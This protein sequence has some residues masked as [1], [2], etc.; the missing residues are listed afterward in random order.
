MQN[1]YL[2]VGEDKYL[3]T[4]E[5]E[6]RLGETT[7]MSATARCGVVVWCTVM[8]CGVPR[9]GV[10]WCAAVWCGGMVW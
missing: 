6:E 4:L 8:W 2:G 1:E 5:L 7:Y 9:C 3:A 10:V